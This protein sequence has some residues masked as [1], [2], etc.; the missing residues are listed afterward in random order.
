MM[1]K[2]RVTITPPTARSSRPSAFLVGKDWRVPDAARHWVAVGLS[3]RGAESPVLLARW[4]RGAAT[5][6]PAGHDLTG[7]SPATGVP[8]RLMSADGVLHPRCFRGS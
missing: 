4:L 1:R 6:F 8:G 3:G 5:A 2:A 7:A